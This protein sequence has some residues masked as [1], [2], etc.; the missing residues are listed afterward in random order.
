MAFMKQIEKYMLLKVALAG[1]HLRKLEKGH[2]HRFM[3]G[4][5]KCHRK[6]KGENVA[7]NGC[8]ATALISNAPSRTSNG[9]WHHFAGSITV[10][11]IALKIALTCRV[12]FS[13]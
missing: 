10:T 3:G 12:R 11:A 4:S 8:H 9:C 5:S 1:H 6:Q 2:F 13:C 7:K